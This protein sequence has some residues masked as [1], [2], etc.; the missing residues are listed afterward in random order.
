[1][2][3]DSLEKTNRL[4]KTLMNGLRGLSYARQTFLCMHFV[5]DFVGIHLLYKDI[6]ASRTELRRSETGPS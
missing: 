6:V 5:I 1:M 2:L 3:T 4:R